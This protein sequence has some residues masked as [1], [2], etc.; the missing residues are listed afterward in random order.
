MNNGIRLSSPGPLNDGGRK[1]N[2]LYIIA[3]IAAVVLWFISP[4][5]A[6]EDIGVVVLFC[7]V[8]AWIIKTGII[9]I[10]EKK[11]RRLQFVL[12]NRIPYEELIEKLILKLVPLGMTIEK[13]RNGEPVITYKNIIYDVSF[14]S[15]NT[16]I[17]WWRK[18]FARALF[19]GASITDYRKQVVAMGIIG[20]HVQ[21]ICSENHEATII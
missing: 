17:I 11:L 5:T 6:I 16:F 10:E 1:Y 21:Q 18:S 14:Q 8:V 2:K 9:G 13:N 15:D 20:Y 19:T 7:L 4:A 3:V 12:D